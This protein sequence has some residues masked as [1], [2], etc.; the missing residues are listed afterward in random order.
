MK[1]YW[2]IVC[3]SKELKDNKVLSRSV[4][5]EWLAI[6][7]GED[8]KAVAFQDRCLHRSAQLSRGCVE[9]GELKCPYHGWVYKASGEVTYVPSE[10]HPKEHTKGHSPRRTN[11]RA[12][13]YPVLEQHD[14]IYVCLN[15]DSQEK[16]FTMPK[17]LA[18]GY[19]NIRLQNLFQNNVINCAENFVD[20][21]HTIFVHPKIF[22]DPGNEK[23]TAKVQR[24]NGAVKVTYLGE[25]SNL[26]IF[27]WFLNPRGGEIQH[28]DEFFTPNITTVNYWLGGNKHFII[29]SQSVP[30]NDQETLVYTDLTYNYGIWNWPS[31]PFVRRHAQKIIDQDIEILG[32]Q[33][34]TIQKYGAHFQ[35][36]PADIIHTFIESL[37]MEIGEGRDPAKLPEKNTEIN[38][39]I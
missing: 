23:L 26:G 18:D 9:K 33:M 10:G 1:N 31:R 8:G 30:K 19:T 2:Y 14:Y 15:K 32:N 24:K 11:R 22:R 7:R 12:V 28:T 17:Y 39:W 20:I 38:F 25:K 27:S 13:I 16:P 37:Q 4:L 34:K 5:G 29:T 3:E 35:N 36:S 6:F 21:P